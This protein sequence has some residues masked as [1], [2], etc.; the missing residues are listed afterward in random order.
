MTRT[1]GVIYWEGAVGV[2]GVKS[3]EDAR[4][5]RAGISRT[6]Q[7]PRPFGHQTVVDNVALAAMFGG[8]VLVAAIISPG[9]TPAA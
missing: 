1:S 5:A 7:I 6:Y 4:I 9:I 3:N 2:S 8:G